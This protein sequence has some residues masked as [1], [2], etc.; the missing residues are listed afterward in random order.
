MIVFLTPFIEKKR[1]CELPEPLLSKLALHGDSDEAHSTDTLKKRS[2]RDSEEAR[3]SVVLRETLIRLGDPDE[4]RYQRL[5][6]RAPRHS[7]EARSRRL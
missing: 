7:D 4:A 5:M 6:K 2:P 3:S 1:T